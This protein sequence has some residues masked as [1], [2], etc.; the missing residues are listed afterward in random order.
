[1]VLKPGP[2]GRLQVCVRLF[3]CVSQ[4]SLGKEGKHTSVS[5]YLRGTVNTGS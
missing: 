5:V 3:V 1:M 4:A 2:D